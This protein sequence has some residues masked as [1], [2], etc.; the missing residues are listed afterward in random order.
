MEHTQLEPSH[1]LFC[2]KKASQHSNKVQPLLYF[3]LL[4]AQIDRPIMK[5]NERAL[6]GK[7]SLRWVFIANSAFYKKPSH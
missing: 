5:K 7:R 6:Y 4:S 1:K 2:L 3:L